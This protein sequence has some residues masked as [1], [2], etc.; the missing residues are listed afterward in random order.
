QVRVEFVPIVHVVAL[1]VL[2]PTI[3]FAQASI[4]GTVK[5]TSGAVLPGATV[6][7]SSPVLI[8]KVRS[9]VS[10]GSG[11]YRIVDLRPGTY[12]VTFSLT[13][14]STVKREGIELSGNFIATV[15]ADLRGGSLEETITVSGAAPIVD[16]Q[17]VA[18]QKVM[19]KDIIDNIPTSRGQYSIASMIVGVTS[20]NPSDVGGKNSINLTRLVSHGSRT[21]DQRFLL[22][23]LSTDSAECAGECSGYLINIRSAEDMAGDRKN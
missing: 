19:G 3:A 9:V 16:V 11:Q 20:N 17:S 6:E 7:A 5:D 8:E 10:D 4:T 12:T 15:N 1:A 18:E 13:G 23:G 14:F 2:V 22:D 21:T